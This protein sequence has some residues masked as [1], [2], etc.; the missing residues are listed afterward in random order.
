LLDSAD[1]DTVSN[2]LLKEALKAGGEDNITVLVAIIE[3]ANSSAKAKAK[4][5]T[6]GYFR[7]API[8]ISKAVK[9]KIGLL[10][11]ILSLVTAILI[12]SGLIFGTYKL[13]GYF[14][15]LKA[16][17]TEVHNP[18]DDEGTGTM[19][20]DTKDSDSLEENDGEQGSNEEDSSQTPVYENSDTQAEWPIEYKVKKGDSLYA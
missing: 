15:G 5:E 13:W 2:L 10:Q 7:G 12:V 3:K 16:S 4:E 8:D 1:T 17:K 14:S 9:S 11:K 19:E 20:P 6:S 18:L